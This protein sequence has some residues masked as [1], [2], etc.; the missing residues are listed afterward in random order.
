MIRKHKYSVKHCTGKL[1]QDLMLLHNGI[2]ENITR[3]VA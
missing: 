3:S 1:I 2:E